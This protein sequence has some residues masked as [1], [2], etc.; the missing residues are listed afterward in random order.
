MSKRSWM[1]RLRG[2]FRRGH[3]DIY[4]AAKA[5][6]DEVGIPVTDVLGAAVSSYLSSDSE[7]KAR[8]ENALSERRKGGGGG[9]GGMAGIEAAL[10]MF[11]KMVDTSVKLMTK[12]QEAGQTLIKG[13]LLNELRG[14]AE[15]IEEIRKI[16]ASGDKGG[17]EDVLAEAFIKRMFEGKG[18]TLSKGKK[19]KKKSGKGKVDEIEEER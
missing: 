4:E 10:G 17:L 15:T 12:S 8:L 13:S 11:E 19:S 18:L 7:G 14:Q 1:D 16:G 9:E 5:Y 3:P 2:V 6:A